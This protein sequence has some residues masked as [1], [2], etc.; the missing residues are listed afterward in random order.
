MSAK[1]FGGS[2]AASSAGAAGGGATGSIVSLMSFS[3]ARGAFIDIH[4]ALVE[5][6]SHLGD[7]GCEVA[8]EARHPFLQLQLGAGQRPVH[9]CG[10]V[11]GG[12]Q[13]LVGQLGEA[14]A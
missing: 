2:A 1:D 7:L 6:G 9:P 4:V 10:P 13:P 11:I 14:T 5:G 3:L 8:C 12:A